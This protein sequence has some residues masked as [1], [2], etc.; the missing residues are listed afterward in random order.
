MLG[1]E[2]GTGQLV[3]SLG[4]DRARDSGQMNGQRDRTMLQ[5]GRKQLVM[6]EGE[7]CRETGPGNREREEQRDGCP[8]EWRIKGAEGGREGKR[9]SYFGK[10]LSCLF[11]RH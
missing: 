11:A 1:E 2:R 3:N 4:K 8:E 5:N 7:E 10:V 6:E 9:G